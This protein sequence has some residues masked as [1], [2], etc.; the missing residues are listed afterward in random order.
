MR[1]PLTKP[2]TKGGLVHAMQSNGPH[3]QVKL[4]TVLPALMVVLGFWQG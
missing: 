3:T 2:K 4:A 1:L